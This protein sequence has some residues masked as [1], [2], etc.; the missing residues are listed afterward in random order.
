MSEGQGGTLLQRYWV[1]PGEIEARSFNIIDGLIPVDRYAADELQIVK[2]VVHTTGD[3]DIVNSLS[4]HPD[5]ISAGLAA[6][7][8]GV[9]IFTDVKMAAAGINRQLASGL[10]CAVGCLIDAPEVAERA[11]ALGVTRAAAGVGHFASQL[12]GCVMAIGNA[13]TALFALLDHVDSGL[14]APALIIGVPV[15]FVGA[16]EAKVELTKR[17]VPFVTVNGARGGSTIAVAIVNALL[18]IAAKRTENASV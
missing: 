5:A 3:P 1:P 17:D 11:T 8:A 4:I 2:R 10:G 7:R 16:A 14:P 9:P 6:L 15:G 18:I 13:P 12:C